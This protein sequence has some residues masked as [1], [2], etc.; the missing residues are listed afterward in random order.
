V[1]ELDGWQ[2]HGHRFAFERDRARDTDLVA[3]G[4][5]VLRFTWRQITDDPVRVII[6]IAQALTVRD[7]NAS[8][9]GGAGT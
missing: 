7:G 3:R 4:Y 5:V 1:V 2:T 8:R 6:R 9:I